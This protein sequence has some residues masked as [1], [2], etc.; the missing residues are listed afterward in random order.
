MARI[1]APLE[2]VLDEAYQRS[3]RRTKQLLKNIDLSSLSWG[4]VHE[5]NFLDLQDTLKHAVGLSYPDAEQEMF[6]FTDASGRFLYVVI[7][8]C[9]PRD[10]YKHF[11]EQQHKPLA[12][13]GSQLK[14][15]DLFWT[16]FEKEGFAIFQAFTKLDY[17]LM[18]YKPSHVYTDHRNLIF[19]F[20]PLT[21]EEALGGHVVS[22]MQRWAFFSSKFRYVIEHVKGEENVFADILPR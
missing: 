18:S 16:T 13:L 21:L 22:K 4:T 2:L 3:S 1:I 17:I 15:T 19:V 5:K 12:F 9:A 14:K 8:Q 6:V 7:T 20:A 10:I 11:P